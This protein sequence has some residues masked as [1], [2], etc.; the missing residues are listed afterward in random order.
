M[1]KCFSGCRPEV[2]EHTEECIKQPTE[3]PTNCEC[4][5][6]HEQNHTCCMPCWNAGFRTV[7]PKS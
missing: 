5:N 6:T 3:R 4:D 1:D 7:A 2:D